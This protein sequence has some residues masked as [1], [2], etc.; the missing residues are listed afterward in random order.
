MMANAYAVYVT[1]GHPS[2]PFYN[3]GNITLEAFRTAERYIVPSDEMMY[4]ALSMLE[5][6]IFPNG[7]V[8]VLSCISE[9]AE[10]KIKAAGSV[11]TVNI[12]D[13][14]H[15]LTR[16]VSISNLCADLRNYNEAMTDDADGQTMPQHAFLEV[17]TP[18]IPLWRTLLAQKERVAEVRG[19]QAKR[20]EFFAGSGLPAVDRA[21]T[22]TLIPKLQYVSV[23]ESVA[24][25]EDD[26]LKCASNEIYKMMQGKE[27]AAMPNDHVSKALFQLRCRSM[28]D[29]EALRDAEYARYEPDRT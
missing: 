12:G 2:A 16:E 4:L 29:S 7:E 10:S 17:N 26:F 25:S 28:K 20:T 6:D 21:E 15:V 1:F 23:F 3:L 13:R 18:G 9:M 24:T 11:I 5:S 27:N 8:S 19:S 14:D 22:P